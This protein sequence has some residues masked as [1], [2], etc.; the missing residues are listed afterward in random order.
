MATEQLDT[1]DLKKTP[2]TPMETEAET[3]IP[4]GKKKPGPQNP[5]QVAEFVSETTKSIDRFLQK[6]HSYELYAIDNAY[7]ALIPEY[8]QSLCSMEDYFK[9]TD[10]K[11]VLELIDD[12]NCKMMQMETEKEWEDQEK[13]PDP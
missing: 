1:V 11:A 9:N 6:M 2:P 8:H 4:P 3:K 7:K 5:D 13:C 10:K 12:K